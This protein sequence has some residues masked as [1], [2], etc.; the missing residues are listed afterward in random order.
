MNI[1]RHRDIYSQC[2]NVCI[3]KDVWTNTQGYI[4]QGHLNTQTYNHLHRCEHCQNSLVTEATR[5][6][7]DAE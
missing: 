4:T 1:L 6:P 3:L 5:Y 2:V 7:Y